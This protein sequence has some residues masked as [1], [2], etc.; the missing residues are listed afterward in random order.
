LEQQKSSSPFGWVLAHGKT[1]GSPRERAA[2]S[3][4]PPGK[5]PVFYPSLGMAAH[6]RWG[7]LLP[8]WG[9][10]CWAFRG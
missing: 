6:G 7:R 10:L 9:K 3:A 1:H 5:V 8:T 4:D 2:G